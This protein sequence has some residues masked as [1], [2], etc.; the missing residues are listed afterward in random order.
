MD[1]IERLPIDNSKNINDCEW[2]LVMYK[3]PKQ[4]PAGMHSIGICRLNPDEIFIK[5]SE[6][7][8]ID[9]SP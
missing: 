6:F 7:L 2:E 5:I 8:G 1:T 9:Q 4:I 3:N